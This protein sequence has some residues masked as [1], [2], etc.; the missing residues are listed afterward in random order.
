MQQNL[1]VDAWVFK[2]SL[3]DFATNNGHKW[4]HFAYHQVNHTGIMYFDVFNVF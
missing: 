3:S 4:L 1:G 2:V